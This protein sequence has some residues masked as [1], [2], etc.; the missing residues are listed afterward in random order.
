MK[1]LQELLGVKYKTQMSIALALTSLTILYLKASSN[2]PVILQ[3]EYIYSTSARKLTFAEY[4]YPNYL[5][6]LV[7]SA[8][9]ACGVGYYWCAK[10]FN[11]VFFVIFLVFV[12]LTARLFL[13]FWQSF[14]IALITSLSPLAMYVGHFMPESMFMAFM[15]GAMYFGVKALVD[16]PQLWT[17]TLASSMMG[18]AALVKPHALLFLPGWILGLYIFTRYRDDRPKSLVVLATLFVPAVVIKLSIGLLLAGTNGLTLLGS[19]YTQSFIEF[20]GKLLAS[21]DHAIA[22]SAEPLGVTSVAN[23]AQPSFMGTFGMQLA[24]IAAALAFVC[25]PLITAVA[26]GSLQARGGNER[27]FSGFLII[28]SSWAALI[29][30]GFT[31][32]VTVLG[33]DH[34]ER[35]L[36]RYIEWLIPFFAI[37]ALGLLRKSVSKTRTGISFLIFGALSIFAAIVLPG[38]ELRPADSSYVVGSFYIEWLGWTL[39]V[40]GFLSSVTLF[41]A[42]KLATASVLTFFAVSSTLTGFSTYQW[43]QA[44]STAYTNVDAAGVFARDFLVDVPTEEI[45]VFGTNKALTEVTVFWIDRPGLDYRFLPSNSVVDMTSLPEGKK[46]ALILDNL[47]AEFGEKEAARFYGRGYFMVR[48]SDQ[49]THYFNEHTVNSPLLSIEGVTRPLHWG[50]WNSQ[51]R[52]NFTFKDEVKAEGKV[53]VTLLASEELATKSF[54]VLA[55]GLLLGE[56]KISEFGVPTAY[57]FSSSTPIYELSLDLGQANCTRCLG[58]LSVVVD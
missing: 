32:L 53:T 37:G 29:A 40:L 14:F 25:L 42:S 34:S 28:Y 54:N 55:N 50:V 43:E 6:G 15:G 10:N 24:F 48:L 1:Y 38:F 36:L 57:E 9:D 5:F 18:L 7:Y 8:T 3:D 22:L 39:L 21:T 19:S 46:Y 47:Q 20:L 35:L 26:S 17:L 52:V 12:Y 30:A 56:V 51:A 45:I 4:D 13:E 31:A 49:K 44:F 27:N 23:P 16:R 33:D 58:L 2:L 41:F 11:L